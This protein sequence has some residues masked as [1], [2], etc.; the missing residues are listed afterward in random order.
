M[1]AEV[2]QIVLDAADSYGD[3]I[4]ENFGTRTLS[5]S[6]GPGQFK[7][8][9]LSGPAAPF[10]LI[11]VFSEPQ[12][13]ISGKM[14]GEQDF[15]RIQ[16]TLRGDGITLRDGHETRTLDHITDFRQKTFRSVRFEPNSLAYVLQVPRVQ[17]ERTVG[18]YLGRD[19][20]SPILFETDLRADNPPVTAWTGL[21]KTYA[22]TW[23][24][25]LFTASPLAASHFQQL[26]LHGLVTAQ[27][28]SLSPLLTAQPATLMTE[29]VKRAA[30]FC[31][32]HAHEP[33]SVTDL[34]IAARTSVRA[35]QKG[36]RAQ[37]GLS[38]L[39]YLRRV[40]L[41]RVHEDLVAIRQGRATGSVTEVALRW[42]FVHLSR[43][44]QFYREAY[45]EAPS[46]TVGLSGK[47]HRGAA[48]IGYPPADRAR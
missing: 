18:K 24:S 7:F 22:E 47:R 4:T 9:L 3:F 25:G 41:A 19:V 35:L 44:A 11:E 30:R 39:G 16:L 20:P 5:F 38:P 48:R 15:Y 27:P 31:E 14:V 36:F 33:I 21:I 37:F 13:D 12:F 23:R 42:G 2:D 43:F 34:A 17:I 32:D 10:D 6:S 40:R 45:R 8:G 46:A 29:A 26:V 28:H 1:A